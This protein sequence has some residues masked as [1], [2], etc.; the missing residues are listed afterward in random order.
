MEIK[1]DRK[2][3]KE[4]YT[5]SNM[6]V[7]GVWFCNVIEDRDRGLR[8]DQP[9]SYI[10]KVKVPSETAIPSGRYRVILSVQ[11]AKFSKKSKY[12]WCKGFLP[13]VMGVPGFDG[14]L[15][16]AGTSA[17]DSAGCLI[18]GMNTE[19][20]KVTSSM[21]TLKKLYEKMQA[22]VQAKETIWL[23]VG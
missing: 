18:V 2:Y 20:G 15:I 10:R 8:S 12:M 1:T 17:A 13:R 4:T 14:I 22:A 3:K 21:V 11:S 6:F 23:T 9:I 19:K 16:H 7:D 5:V